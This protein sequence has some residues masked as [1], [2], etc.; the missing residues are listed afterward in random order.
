MNKQQ[1][2]SP[3]SGWAEAV[4][5]PPQMPSDLSTLS[6]EALKDLGAVLRIQLGPASVPGHSGVTETTI[7]LWVRTGLSGP[8]IDRSALWLSAAEPLVGE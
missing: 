3:D 6:F 8:A 4:T 1:S 7:E 5:Q 2:L